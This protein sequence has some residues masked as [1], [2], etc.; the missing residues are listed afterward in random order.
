MHE[1]LYMNERLQENIYKDN[2]KLGS[3]KENVSGSVLL[4]WMGEVQ[5]RALF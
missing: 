5:L 4:G 3:K 1:L 2:L